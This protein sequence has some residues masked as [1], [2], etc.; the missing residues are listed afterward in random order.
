MPYNHLLAL[1]S[2]FAAGPGI[3]PLTSV[4]AG[5]SARNYPT[6]LA[7][8]L[9]TTIADHTASGATTDSVVDSRQ[10]VRFR[11]LPPQLSNV[12]ANTDLITITAGGNDVGYIGT[13]IRL[14][15]AERLAAH[16]LARPIAAMIRGKATGIPPVDTQ[17]RVA[18]SLTRIIQGARGVAPD[19]R[20]VLV[21]YLT[22]IGPVTET[23]REA[24]FTN[25]QLGDFANF[26]DDL[27]A[28]FRQAAK[29][30]AVDLVVMS[31]LS[32]GHAL[33]SPDPWV[34]GLPEHL[35]EMVRRPPFHPNIAG[36]KATAEAIKSL[37]GE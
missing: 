3:D 11:T 21:D 10:R 28:G 14:A 1:G 6:L 35:T 17:S 32:R 18:D 25:Q 12:P 34:V 2:S 36:M 8:M 23:S 33:G 4:V 20:I 29:S 13:M 26:A 5:R 15:V 27:S 19:A 30:A 37:I 31:E 7:H 24:P 22:I 9:G 16:L